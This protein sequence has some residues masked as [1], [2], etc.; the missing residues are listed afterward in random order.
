MDTHTAYFMELLPIKFLFKR[1][2]TMIKRYNYIDEEWS[3]LQWDKCKVLILG[4]SRRSLCVYFRLKNLGATVIGF[5][6]SFVTDEEI[7][8]ACLPVYQY[9]V[10][11]RSMGARSYMYALQ[12]KMRLQK[13]KL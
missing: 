9:D 7:S 11:L 3:H 4:I 2:I 1:E 13:E 6:D 8:F 12:Q 5:T 10:Y